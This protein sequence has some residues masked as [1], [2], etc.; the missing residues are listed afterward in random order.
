VGALST[1]LAHSKVANVGNRLKLKVLTKQYAGWTELQAPGCAY[2]VTECYTGH[3]M[4]FC[5][6]GTDPSG[7]MKLGNFYLL[8]DY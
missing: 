8:K 5:E 1:R 6:H 4:R 2:N 3:W 7:S